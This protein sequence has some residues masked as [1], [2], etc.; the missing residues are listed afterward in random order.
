M[1]SPLTRDVVDL[2]ERTGVRRSVAAEWWPRFC[3]GGGLEPTTTAQ[4]ILGTS[5][6]THADT[7][8]QQANRATDR[9]TKLRLRELCDEVLASYHQVVQGADF[10]GG[11]GP[12]GLNVLP[13]S[14]SLVV[15]GNV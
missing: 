13:P 15:T 3:L 6:M 2:D 5:N 1:N 8:T 9:R 11:R 14:S 12:R 7:T 10:A 4:L